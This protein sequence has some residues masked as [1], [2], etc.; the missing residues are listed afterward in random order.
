VGEGGSVDVWLAR[1]VAKAEARWGWVD[2]SVRRWLGSGVVLG[3][4]AVG[5]P[6]GLV[7]L[8]V[9]VFIVGSLVGGLGGGG[10]VDIVVESLSLSRVVKEEILASSSLSL[11]SRTV[12]LRN[13]VGVFFGG[14]VGGSAKEEILACREAEVRGQAFSWLMWSLLSRAVAL[15]SE[16]GVC[17]GGF[18]GGSGCW[19]R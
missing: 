5:I 14:F 10:M 6:G 13:E 12:A 15:W 19:A 11:L 1:K 2:R 3:A 18:V 8:A 17:F 9:V 16:V 4:L 7:V